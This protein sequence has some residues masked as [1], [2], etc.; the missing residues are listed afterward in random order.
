MSF[1]LGRRGCT[2]ARDVDIART[3][4][5]G[6]SRSQLGSRAREVGDISNLIAVPRRKLFLSNC[7]WLV[8]V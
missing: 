4:G 1:D 2:P 7:S 8:F 3:W 6:A 5:D